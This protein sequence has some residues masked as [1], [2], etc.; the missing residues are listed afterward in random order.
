MRRGILRTSNM[1]ALFGS[2]KKSLFVVQPTAQ[3]TWTAGT[4]VQLSWSHGVFVLPSFRRIFGNHSGNLTAR[5]SPLVSCLWLSGIASGGN[6]GGLKVELYKGGRSVQLL[7]DG[8]D[9]LKGEISVK[10]PHNLAAGPDYRIRLTRH[11]PNAHKVDYC[12]LFL[13]LSR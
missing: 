13:F 5:S 4:T 12:F 7:T 11:Y 1:Q 10:L 6:R 3:T 9:L 8:V 2:K